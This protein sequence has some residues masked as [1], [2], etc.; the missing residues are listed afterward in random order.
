MNYQEAKAAAEQARTL[1]K[2]YGQVLSAFPRGPMGL[3]PDHIKFSPPY[4][5]AKANYDA[6][7]AQERRVNAYLNKHFKKEQQQER[8]ERYAA[9][10]QAINVPVDESDRSDDLESTTPVTYSSPRP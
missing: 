1:S 2:Q 8:R 6:A 10:T 3:T 5:Q 4:R 9:R 7:F